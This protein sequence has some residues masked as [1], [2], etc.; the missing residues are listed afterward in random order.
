MSSNT[1]L[2]VRLTI[3]DALV[4]PLP[5]QIARRHLA[6]ARAMQA[7]LAVREIT[8]TMRERHPLE[9]ME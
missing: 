6:I 8:A 2:G 3:N 5:V 4:P 1:P 7:A 9:V